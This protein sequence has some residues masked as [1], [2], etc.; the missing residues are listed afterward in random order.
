MQHYFGLV[1]PFSFLVG[2]EHTRI[3]SGGEFRVSFWFD[4]VERGK[5]TS[6]T[7]HQRIR[8]DDDDVHPMY[9]VHKFTF[10][11]CCGELACG[12]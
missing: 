12:C 9:I 6:C 1:C 10:R 7:P 2:D 3:V 4:D 11:K 8:F 5:L